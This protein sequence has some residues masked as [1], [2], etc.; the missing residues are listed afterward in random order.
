M[1]FDLTSHWV[2]AIAPGPR[3]DRD[4]PCGPAR[5]G[6][7]VPAASVG[8]SGVGTARLKPMMSPA[9]ALILVARPTLRNAFRSALVIALITITRE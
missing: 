4:T 3:A 2:G 6:S 5:A 1:S 8:R 9:D 7:D